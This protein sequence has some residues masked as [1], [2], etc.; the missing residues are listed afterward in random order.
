M[1]SFVLD[2]VLPP[3]WPWAFL[4]LVAAPLVPIW[5]VGGWSVLHLRLCIL[6]HGWNLGYLPFFRTRLDVSMD[7]FLCDVVIDL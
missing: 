4:F 7:F 6:Y 5:C 2:G 3:S 1:H